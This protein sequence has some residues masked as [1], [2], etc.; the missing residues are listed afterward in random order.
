MPDEQD[1]RIKLGIEFS[2]FELNADTKKAI[3]QVCES[4]GSCSECKF[5]E[6]TKL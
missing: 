1:N 6:C 5:D 4:V 2:E 3:H